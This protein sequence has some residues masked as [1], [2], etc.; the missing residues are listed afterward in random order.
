MKT[1]RTF[2][3]L[4]VGI[5]LVTAVA[6]AGCAETPRPINATSPTVTYNY[7]TDS[8]L[9]QANQ[10]ATSYCAQY[11]TYP[12]TRTVTNN[13]DGSRTVVFDCVATSPVASTPVMTTPVVTTPVMTTP[14]VTTPV[15]VAQVPA[16][17]RYTYRTDQELIQAS[18][19]AGAY[20]ARA[21]SMPM[22]STIT[23]NVDGSRT[24]TF[25]CAR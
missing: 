16:G 5:G 2:R 12:Q 7:R 8:E 25:Q 13:S 23:T 21:G 18:Q 17:M 15:V 3:G 22:T 10:N 20:C 24:V 4:G 6:L 19:T 11:S 9:V 1:F 14:V